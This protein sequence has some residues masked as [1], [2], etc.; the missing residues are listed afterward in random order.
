MIFEILGFVYLIGLVIVGMAAMLAFYGV[1]K[2]DPSGG[3]LAAFIFLA[4][5]FVALT[6]PVSIPIMAF[7][8]WRRGNL[9]A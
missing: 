8:K 5:G 2:V 4:Y 1:K 3:L 6:W 9:N 7:N